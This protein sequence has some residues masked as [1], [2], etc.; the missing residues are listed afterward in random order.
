MFFLIATRAFCYQ[1]TMEND[2]PLNNN[3]GLGN[4]LNPGNETVRPNWLN[5]MECYQ[6]TMENNWPLNNNDGQGNNSLNPGNETGHL[7]WL[8]SLEE[9]D[10]DALM[11]ADDHVNNDQDEDDEEHNLQG[12]ESSS[13]RSGKRFTA[14]QILGL[15]S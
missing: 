15:E 10:M 13:K 5:N 6:D 12:A 8:N 2:I 4:S 1:D 9:Y 11:G 3:D 14:E 7:N